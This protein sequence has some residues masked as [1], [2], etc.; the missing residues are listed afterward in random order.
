MGVWP[1]GAKYD[2]HVYLLAS[3]NSD[4]L[5]GMACTIFDV[6]LRAIPLEVYH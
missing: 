4:F 6:L 2:S 5:V 1:Y 3:L